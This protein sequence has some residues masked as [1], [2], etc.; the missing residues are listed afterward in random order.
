MRAPL[1]AGA[2]ARGRAPDRGPQKLPSMSTDDLL[3]GLGLVIVLAFACRLVADRTRLPAIVLLLPVGF[4]AGAATDVVHPDVLFGDTFSAI[5]DLG[6]GLILFEAGLRLRRHE[7]TGGIRRAVWRLVAL[8]VVLGAALMVVAVKLLFGVGWNVALVTGAILVVSGP[9]VV[10]PLLAF[11]RPEAR[12]RTVLKFEGVLVDPFGA[13]LG[14]S[15][16]AVTQEDYHP[17][18][19]A[20]GLLVGAAVGVVGAI[21]LR[22]VLR[23]VTRE[24]PAQSVTAT[25]MLVVAAIVAADTLRDDSGFVAATVMGVALANQTELD[26]SRVVA[27]QATIV[28]LLIAMLFVLISASVEPSEVADVLVKGLVLVAIIVV[29]IRPLVVA[30]ST[31]GTPFGRGERAFMAWMAPRG[32]VAAATASAFGIGL[33][34]S[35]VA[36]ADEILPIT[37]VVILGTVGL[38]GLTA[39]PVARLLGVKGADAE[40]VLVIGGHAWARQIAAALAAA[41]MRVRVWTSHAGEQAAARE[42]GLDAGPPQLGHDVMGREEEL[43]EVSDA[44]VMTESDD[45]NLVATLELHHELGSEHVFTLPAREEHRDQLPDIPSTRTLF[46]A[47]QT[48]PALSRRFAA[49]ARVTTAGHGTRLFVVTRDGDLRVVA[50]GHA[51]AAEAGD[52][53]IDLVDAAPGA[54]QADVSG[55]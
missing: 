43:E 41:G 37:F 9:T 40:T 21:A 31:I 32:I 16:F 49:G 2:A 15:A 47:D 7:L 23:R 14:V 12:V 1:R 5:V 39:S 13:L 19:V 48:F 46:G 55:S 8:G 22:V 42:A 52:T 6:V 27:F 44:L 29:V 11:V 24:S 3:R 20:A 45:F 30:L 26:L 18:G 28:E 4:A 36:G 17:G 10:L 51:P 33:A 53:E 34:Q 38:Y 35:G 54:G 50:E 25:L